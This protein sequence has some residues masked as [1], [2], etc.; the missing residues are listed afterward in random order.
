MALSEY[1]VRCGQPETTDTPRY[2][3]TGIDSVGTTKIDYIRRTL[4][5]K[6]GQLSISFPMEELCVIRT[7]DG[8]PMQSGR[9]LWSIGR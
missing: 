2:V 6:E 3:I 4:H 8:V 1:T 9:W 7:V 5:H